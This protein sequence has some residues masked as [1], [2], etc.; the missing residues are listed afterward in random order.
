MSKDEIMNFLPG[1]YIF[2]EGEFGQTAFMI[3]SGTVELVKFTGDQQTVLTELENGALFGEMAIIDGSA[4]SASARAKTE[5]VLK[6]IAEEQLKKHLSSSPT[7]SLDMMRRLAS[8]VRT[9]N[10]RLNRDAFSEEVGTSLETVNESTKS[11]AVDTYTQ[12]TLREFNDDLDE[13]AKISPKKPLAIAGMTIIAMV[14][15]FGVWASLA[16]ID[17]TVSARGKILTS[18][19]NVEVQSNHSSVIKTILV[20]EGDD[21]LKGQPI[22]LFDE[23]LIA[24]DFRNTRD[25][26]AATDTDIVR[27]KAE[28]NYILDQDFKAPTGDLQLAMFDDQVREIKMQKQDH[29]TKILGLEVKVERTALKALGLREE[30]N[31]AVRPDIQTKRQR[32]N[33]KRQLLAFLQK[34]PYEFDQNSGA[35][36]YFNSKTAEIQISLA[37]LK[38]QL[39]LSQTEVDRSE[40]LIAAKIISDAE[41]EKKVHSLDQAK[42]KF[43]KYQT[44]QIASTFEDIQR[45]STELNGLEQRERK[46]VSDIENISIDKEENSLGLTKANLEQEKFISGKLREKN[47]LLKDL[48]L[49]R[50]SSSEKLLKLSRQIEDVKLVAPIAGTILKLEDQFQGTVIKPG[51][52]IA[53]LVPN[54]LDFHVEVDIDPSDITH[55]YEGA[56]VKIMLDSLPSQKHGELLGVVSLLSKDTVDEDVFGEKNSVYRAEIKITENNLVKLPEGFKLLPS[57][58]VNGNIISGKRTVMTFL[59][60]PVIK[61]LETSF[62]EP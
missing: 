20:R 1:D 27:T 25:E 6:V 22:A 36:D 2:R 31:K 44:S 23:T 21:V 49:K 35:L 15:S 24:S 3:E 26:L 32:L 56:K 55:V 61:T 59:L 14:V 50:K 19:A 8:Y 45:L 38:G 42:I 17:V 43:E 7:A 47:K 39:T 29:D 30:L 33:V 57:M 62:R 28:L 48:A 16:E 37:D 46:L 40:G 52:V 9:A 4:R 10:E 13:F 53:T 41:Y 12:R 18:I 58:S 5:C 60:F 51:D 34:K 54:D 11:T